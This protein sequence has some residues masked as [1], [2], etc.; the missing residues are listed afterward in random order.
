[1]AQFSVTIISVHKKQY[2]ILV[3]IFYRVDAGML[4]SQDDSIQ[5][6]A[7]HLIQRTELFGKTLKKDYPIINGDVK[8]INNDYKIH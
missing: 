7:I 1:M 8:R 4:H 5:K 6:E 3:C 2:C